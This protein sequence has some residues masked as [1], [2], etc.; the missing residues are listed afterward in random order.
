M[1]ANIIKLERKY[2][3]YRTNHIL[4]LILSLLTLGIWVVIWGLVT[5]H[6]HGMRS[7]IASELDRLYVKE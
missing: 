2:N 5:L 3:S 1:N 6:N 4:H 7:R